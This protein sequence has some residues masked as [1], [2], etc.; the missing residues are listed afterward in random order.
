MAVGVLADV[1][2]YVFSGIQP[3]FS[4][5][6]FFFCVI[7]IFL[8]EKIQF[9]LKLKLINYGHI[10]AMLLKNLLL[11]MVLFKKILNKCQEYFLTLIFLPCLFRNSKTRP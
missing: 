2:L 11:H 7:L 5:I 1:F 4:Q 6:N 8:I 3:F 10:F 9:F